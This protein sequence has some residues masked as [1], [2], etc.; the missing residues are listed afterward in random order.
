VRADADLNYTVP[1]LVDGE[2][3]RIKWNSRSS[4]CAGA[5]FNSGQSCCAVEVNHKS[6]HSCVL[7]LIYVQRIYVHESI[8]DSFVSSF[9]DIVKVRLF[10]ALLPD[11]TQLNTYNR[12][13]NSAILPSRTRIWVPLSALPVHRGY[14]S[15]SQ[16]PVSNLNY[17]GALLSK[18][19]S[20]QSTQARK[21]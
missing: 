8:F 19:H 10:V 17:T 2:S 5:M 12:N 14:G 9:V 7:S 13:T 16:M 18:H 11:L 4:F 20:S 1:E 21:L 6:F 3:R 15:K